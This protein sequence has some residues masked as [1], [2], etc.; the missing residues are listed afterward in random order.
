MYIGTDVHEYTMLVARTR[1]CSY[2]T[3]T[4]PERSQPL[5]GQCLRPEESS[6]ITNSLR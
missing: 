4:K 2:V 5:L 6:F 3:V 1:E